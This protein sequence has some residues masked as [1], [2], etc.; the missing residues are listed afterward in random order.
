RVEVAHEGLVFATRTTNT[1]A[2]DISIPV[3]AQ[4]ARFVVTFRDGTTAEATVSVPELQDYDRVAMVWSGQTDINIHALEFGARYGEGGDV[5][6]GAPRS[7]EIASHARG[8]FL[9]RLGDANLEQPIQ[10]EIYSFPTGT[11]SRDGVVRLNV[12]AKVTAYSCGRDISARSAQ[13]RRGESVQWLD[14]TLAVPECD[15]IGDILVLKNL[16][17]DL[18][19]ARN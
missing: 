18:K 12:E 10:A 5:W 2:L 6:A 3:L 17:Q 7:A 15:A 16:L 1:G 9:T 19:I 4:D 11:I 14:L 13:L 8:G